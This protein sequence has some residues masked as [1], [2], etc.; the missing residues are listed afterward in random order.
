MDCDFLSIFKLGILLCWTYSHPSENMTNAENHS[1]NFPLV[2]FNDPYDQYYIISQTRVAGLRLHNWVFMQNKLYSQSQHYVPLWNV[3]PL[4]FKW[5]ERLT[6]KMLLP[7]WLGLEGDVRVMR[8]ARL[9]RRHHK[10]SSNDP[11]NF[12]TNS[13]TDKFLHLPHGSSSP[14]PACDIKTPFYSVFFEHEGIFFVTSIQRNVNIAGRGH[15]SSHP[16]VGPADVIRDNNS[17]G[18]PPSSVI[19]DQTQK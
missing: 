3:T 17:A 7:L 12:P 2:A 15:P 11:A 8:E 1:V 6:D 19:T 10:H 9:V 18:R 13:Q 5:L 4:A 16:E 14:L